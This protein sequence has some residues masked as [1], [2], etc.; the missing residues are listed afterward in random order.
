MGKNAHIDFIKDTVVEA[1]KLSLSHLDQHLAVETKSTHSDL[2]TIADREV[3]EF[4]TRKIRDVFPDHKIMGEESYKSEKFG[5]EDYVWLVDPIDGTTNFIHQK[6]DYV[7]S[8]A[9]AHR[10]EIICGGVYD[11]SRGELFYAEKNKGAFLG[12]KAL[13]IKADT[14]LSDSLLASFFFYNGL[15]EESDFYNFMNGL[16]KKCH[17]MRILGCA[18]LELCYVAA[19]RLDGYL[20]MGLKPWDIAAGKLIVEEAGGVVTRLDGSKIYS[21]EPGT[22]LASGASLHREILQDKEAWAS[23]EI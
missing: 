12:S 22:L 20:H 10:N 18:A 7:C 9:L 8:I 14:K 4:I 23:S 15:E 2:V 21:Y 1:G 6:L 16:A 5:S 19:G 17:G 3:E 11:P 13:S